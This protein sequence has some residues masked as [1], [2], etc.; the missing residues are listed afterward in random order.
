LTSC[1]TNARR[2]QRLSLRLEVQLAVRC[3]GHQ[4]HTEDVGA[5]GCR[6]LVPMH[7]PAGS[8]VRLLLLPAAA[9][10]LLSIDARVIWSTEAPGWR[11]GLAFAAADAGRAAAWFDELVAGSLSLLDR[12]LVAIER[13]GTGAIER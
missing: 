4:G 13:G 5:G 11:H 7:L 9:A 3:V 10:G 2:D 12:G 1:A 8:R 6:L